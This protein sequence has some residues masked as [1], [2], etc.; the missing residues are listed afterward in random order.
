MWVWLVG[1]QLRNTHWGCL[2]CGCR[3]VWR[4]GW[5]CQSS[6][7]TRCTSEDSPTRSQWPSAFR[8]WPSRCPNHLQTGTARARVHRGGENCL[9]MLLPG[10]CGNSIFQYHNNVRNSNIIKYWCNSSKFTMICGRRTATQLQNVKLKTYLSLIPEQG[11]ILP[12]WWDQ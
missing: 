7:Q 2:R 4:P 3:T 12:M 8:W 1:S 11:L 10:R 9:L 6:H 5:S